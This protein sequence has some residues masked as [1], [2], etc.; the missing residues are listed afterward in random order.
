MFRSVDFLTVYDIYIYIYIYIY[1]ERER[2]RE[3]DLFEWDLRGCCLRDLLPNVSPK[4]Q[5]CGPK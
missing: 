5:F 4:V 2:E 3:R 1:I